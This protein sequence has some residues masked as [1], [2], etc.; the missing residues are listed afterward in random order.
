MSISSK[1]YNDCEYNI[2]FEKYQVNKLKFVDKNIHYLQLK[3]HIQTLIQE[4]KCCKPFNQNN[5]QNR[6]EDTKSHKQ[7]KYKSYDNYSKQN[8]QNYRHQNQNQRF[9][10]NT[11]QRHTPYT[12]RNSSHKYQYNQNHVKP[13]FNS[14]SLNEFELY[15]K[16]LR[17]HLNKYTKINKEKITNKIKTEFEEILTND[18][19]EGII[20]IF[21]DTFFEMITKENE[22]LKLY[23]ELF[24]SIFIQHKLWNEYKEI[25]LK[26]IETK[27]KTY[28]S[29]IK[30]IPIIDT[31]DYDA[32]CVYNKNSEKRIQYFT[33]SILIYS[34]FIWTSNIE[35]TINHAFDILYG[36]WKEQIF[37]EKYT[38][39]C[40][41]IIKVISNILKNKSM[42]NIDFLKSL[43][44]TVNDICNTVI[45]KDKCKGLSN[46]SYFEILNLKM[47]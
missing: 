29:D 7:Y 46:K 14:K 11:L 12:S 42:L 44:Y 26:Y 31:S 5:N 10:K 38:T 18:N 34:N 21:L 13:L 8:K 37:D 47:N 9:K 19:N 1:I 40:T 17:S 36:M 43:K 2:I 4:S 45:H 30:D 25:F 20:T 3:S 41:E 16:S 23:L 35:I 22:Y 33:L 39:S 28:I 27:N 6:S 15:K 32:F 24:E